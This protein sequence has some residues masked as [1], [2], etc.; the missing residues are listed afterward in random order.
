MPAINQLV[1]R[2]IA[3]YLRDVGLEWVGAQSIQP[4][5]SNGPVG[6]DAEAESDSTPL[7]KI[8]VMC[9]DSEPVAVGSSQYRCNASV[10][11]HSNAD[12]TDASLHESHCNEV[13]NI[14]ED[15]AAIEAALS[16]R[17]GF[18]TQM[19]VVRGQS[20]RFEGR[21]WVSEIRIELFAASA[22]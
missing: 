13:F 6:D 11:V 14:F 5:F 2:T 1:A 8:V 7:P 3:E 17:P 18:A 16:L 21:C 12:D 20:D 9:Q 19:V 4:M 15:R 10:E 22:T